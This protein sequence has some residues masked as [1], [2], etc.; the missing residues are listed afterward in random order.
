MDMRHVKI[1]LCSVL[2]LG[3][4]TSA[5]SRG[6]IL[7]PA[8]IPADTGAVLP[9]PLMTLLPGLSRYDLEQ[10]AVVR[11]DGADDSLPHTITTRALVLVDILQNSDSS[12]DVTV[13]VDSL[14]QIAEG[15]NRPLPTHPSSL[16][17]VLRVSFGAQ[18]NSV[19]TQLADSLC[20]YGQFVT[21]AR[22]LVLPT[23]PA[24]VGAELRRTPP[25][26]LH[27]TSC[28]AG[29]PIRIE[30][31][32]EVRSLKSSPLQV[33]IDERARVEGSGT[34]QRDSITIDGSLRTQGTAS[35]AAGSRLPSLVETRSEGSI[36]IGLGDSTVTF[37]QFLTHQLRRR[38]PQPPN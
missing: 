4:C 36:R 20:A 3:A 15:F 37:K 19:H 10:Q 18:G 26:T 29:V 30:S 11:V 16:G 24:Q 7:P 25:D 12:Y 1:A 21:I 32:Q 13:S 5:R 34:M 14:N 27:I 38:E 33:E 23:M 9:S 8:G 2:A 35:F 6:D 31:T 28:R 17:T 22:Q